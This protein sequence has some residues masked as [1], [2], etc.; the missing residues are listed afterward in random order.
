MLQA[1]SS[2]TQTEAP[3]AQHGPQMAGHSGAKGSRKLR[4][5]GRNI[6]SVIGKIFHHKGDSSS[7][8]A[9]A[10]AAAGQEPSADQDLS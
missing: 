5:I 4:T 9:A 8:S 2:G 10:P 3:G 1:S 7:S 6:N